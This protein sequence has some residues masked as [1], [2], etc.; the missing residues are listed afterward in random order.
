MSAP[1]I[2]TSYTVTSIATVG[3][4]LDAGLDDIRI[5]EIAP[6]S[7]TSTSTLN[8]TSTVNSVSKLTSDSKV[9]LGLDNIQIKEL[10]RIDLQVAMK[11]T[12]VHFPVNLHFGLSSL[13]F[14]LLT[15]SVCGESMV[16]IEDYVPHKTEI[17]R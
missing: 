8:S 13:G 15:F 17:C 3:G 1:D 5:K 2:P 7:L 16:V 10:P 9:D 11:P 6:V 12:R 14:P 4:S